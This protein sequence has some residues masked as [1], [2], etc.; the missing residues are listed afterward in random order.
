MNGESEQ[1]WH[2][3]ASMETDEISK[4]ILS[5]IED[6]AKEFVSRSLANL[7][8]LQHKLL[9]LGY[10]FKHPDV[11]LVESDTRTA[12]SVSSLE[13]KFGNLPLVLRHWYDVIDSVDFSQTDDQ[14]NAAEY[15]DESQ[16]SLFGLGF[17]SVLYFLSVDRSLDMATAIEDDSNYSDFES[18]HQSDTPQQNGSFFPMGGW[19]SNNEP[20]GFWLP[21]K[22]VDDVFYNPGGGDILFTDELRRAFNCGGFPFWETIPVG[23]WRENIVKKRPD[24]DQLLPLLKDGLKPV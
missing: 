9:D 10:K 1:V 18:D 2:E 5:D 14:L 22:R 23:D 16:P 6:V 11:I 7:R 13:E 20:K 24:Y 19:A 3:I 8:T 15:V 17:N 12:A 4:R 21:S